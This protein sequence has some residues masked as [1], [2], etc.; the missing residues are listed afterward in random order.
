[1]VLGLLITTGFLGVALHFH[2]F[3]L[4]S[5]N[6][7]QSDTRLALGSQLLIYLVV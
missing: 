4:R 2:W 6:E 1:M 3:G 5:F 7:A